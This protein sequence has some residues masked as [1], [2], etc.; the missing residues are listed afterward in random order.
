MRDVSPMQYR[1]KDNMIKDKETEFIKELINLM[2]KYSLKDLNDFIKNFFDVRTTQMD[3]QEE[4]EYK[5]E[6]NI[7]IR[8]RNENNLYYICFIEDG[9]IT[10]TKTSIACPGNYGDKLIIKPIATNHIV[11]Y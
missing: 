2:N 1:K 9:G 6:K 11:I 5:Q 7:G 4:V 10:I 3:R 8:F